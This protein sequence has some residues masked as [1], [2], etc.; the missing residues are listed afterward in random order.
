MGPSTCSPSLRS[1]PSAGTSRSCV[2]DSGSEEP[3]AP[4]GWFPEQG[5]SGSGHHPSAASEHLLS[6]G[7]RLH[8]LPRD[9]GHGVG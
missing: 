4:Q 5:R 9:R 6:Q 2:T 7:L 8:S 1:Q 3:T